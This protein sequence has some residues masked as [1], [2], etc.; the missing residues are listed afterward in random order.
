MDAVKNRAKAINN[1]VHPPVFDENQK[2]FQKSLKRLKK[3]A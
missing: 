1:C 2:M 3:P